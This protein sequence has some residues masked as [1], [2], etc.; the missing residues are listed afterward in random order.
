MLVLGWA[1]AS[2]NEW[3]RKS[4]PAVIA[5]LISRTAATSAWGGEV[6]GMFGEHRMHLV[7]NRCDQVSEKV[8][9]YP[10]GGLRVQLDGRELG[11][12]VATW[13]WS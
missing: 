13:R 4:S 12:A 9:R 11:R 10:G 5:A 1:Q 6:D 8:S 2:S 3:A 7:G